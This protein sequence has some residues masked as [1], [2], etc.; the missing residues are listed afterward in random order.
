LIN[1]T[2]AGHYRRVDL[3]PGGDMNTIKLKISRIGN[4]GRVRIPAGTLA[5][6]GITDS[7]V[8][9]ER[10]D[11]ILLRPLGRA[12][13]KLS[14]EESAAAMSKADEDWSEWEATAGDEI[15]LPPWVATRA[16]RGKAR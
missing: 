4:S 3:R 9:E 12:E 10:S 6:Y 11:G 16:P 8:M 1:V 2:R 7:V 14:W 13:P 15:A 5:R